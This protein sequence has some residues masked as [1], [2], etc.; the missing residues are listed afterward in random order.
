[1]PGIPYLLRVL[2]ETALQGHVQGAV[3]Q[4]KACNKAQGKRLQGNAGAGC[5]DP[6]SL[7][8]MP[9]A[10]ASGQPCPQ[11]SRCASLQSGSS[12]KR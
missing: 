12:P 1:M 10:V 9:L 5:N 3:K 11:Q 6:V 8:K 7:W 2:E 4:S